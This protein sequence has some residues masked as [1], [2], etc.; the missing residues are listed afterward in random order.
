M[1]FLI[2]KN[3]QTVDCTK[4]F[5]LVS[6]AVDAIVTSLTFRTHQFFTY[7]ITLLISFLISF[8]LFQH[9]KN[10]SIMMQI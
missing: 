2:V 4:F 7:C 8:E 5:C 1:L 10:I 6:L 9:Q 3:I